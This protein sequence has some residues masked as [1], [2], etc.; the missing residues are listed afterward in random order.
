MNMKFAS[1]DQ[2]ADT[3][4]QAQSPS[5]ADPVDQRP[6]KQ[7]KVVTV[8]A[9]WCGYTRK[10]VDLLKEHCAHE[11]SKIA[12]D[13]IQPERLTDPEV[14]KSL[15]AFPT[16]FCC[17]ADEDSAECAVQQHKRGKSHVGMR[18][19]KDLERMCSSE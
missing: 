4:A 2:G 15:R 1:F 11:D 5:L 14:A 7:R 12:Y 9:D 13:Y 3:T 8:G 18:D 17:N 10:Q 6:K 16:S 19:A